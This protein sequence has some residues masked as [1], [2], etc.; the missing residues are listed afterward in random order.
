MKIIRNKEIVKEEVEIPSGVYYYEVDLR[1]Y[2]MS[3]GDTDEHGYTKYELVSLS[4]FSN[5]TAIRV[6]EDECTSEDVPY[7]FKQFI[8]EGMGR[9]ITEEE[10][11]IEKQEILKRVL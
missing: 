7:D 8:L 3:F 10:F 9:K 1:S 5:V 11:N 6:H 4:N 2:R